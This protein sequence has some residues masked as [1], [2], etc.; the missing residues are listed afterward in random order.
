VLGKYI[1]EEKI[2]PMAEMLK[3]ITSVPARNFGF[4]QR[5]ALQREYFADIVIFDEKRVIDKATFKDPHQYPEGID[6]VIVNGQVVINNGEH[7]GLLP[8]KILRKQA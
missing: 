7:S 6:Y 8:G 1:R 3:K 5:G 4:A 2:L